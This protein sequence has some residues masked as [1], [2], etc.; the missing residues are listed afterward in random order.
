MR[1]LDQGAFLAAAAI[2]I[3]L[4]S[5]THADLPC[6]IGCFSVNGKKGPFVS[7]LDAK[8]IQEARQSINV[9]P[10]EGKGLGEHAANRGEFKGYGLAM[11]RTEARLNELLAGVRKAM[12]EKWPELNP[13]PAPIHMIGSTS[14]GPQAMA[15]GSIVVPLGLIIR[16]KSDE[17][18]VWVMSHEL[19]HLAL[20]HFARDAAQERRKQL[21]DELAR[22]L[23]T[24]LQMSELRAQN[25]T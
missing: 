1:M 21:I 6:L 20:A 14:Y 19:S 3:L 24:A 10:G 18:V 22:A 25:T 12:Q 2:A 23:T 9:A 17:E 16:A 8:H 5:A 15:D 13:G 7:T 4:P 11:P